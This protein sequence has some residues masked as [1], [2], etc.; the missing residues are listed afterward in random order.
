MVCCCSMAGTAACYRCYGYQRHWL[1]PFQYYLPYSIYE[2]NEIFGGDDGLQEKE[3]GEKVNE[4][5]G[6]QGK[7]DGYQAKEAEEKEKGKEIVGLNTRRGRTG[8]QSKNGA[9]PSPTVTWYRPTGM[10]HG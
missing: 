7:L 2:L 5:E 9:T 10:K 6:F 1:S 8:R 3:K 4:E